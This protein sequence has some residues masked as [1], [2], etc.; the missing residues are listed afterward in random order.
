MS[1]EKKP[2]CINYETDLPAYVKSEPEP[3]TDR[4]E[5]FKR[6]HKVSDTSEDIARLRGEIQ[7]TE[8]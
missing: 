2:K 7:W 6:K 4:I 8:K 5:E 3:F 1:N